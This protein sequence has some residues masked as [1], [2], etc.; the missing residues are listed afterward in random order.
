MK[1]VVSDLNIFVKKWFKIA[2]AKKVLKI[3]FHLFTPFKPLFVPVSQKPMYKLLR[4][5]ESLGKTNGK[6]WSQILV[7]CS[8]RVLN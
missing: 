4:F 8:K 1:E 3:F 6:K 2:A 5:L 7:L